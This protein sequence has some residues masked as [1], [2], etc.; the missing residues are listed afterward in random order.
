MF[1]WIGLGRQYEYLLYGTRTVL[2]YASK[3]YEKCDE[4]NLCQPRGP[5]KTSTD[6]AASGRTSPWHF[7]RRT[8]LDT[9]DF[10]AVL[11]YTI[12]DRYWLMKHSGRITESLMSPGGCLN[13]LQARSGR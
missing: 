3:F 6:A 5:N 4:K 10:S 8:H 1:S 11:P 9:S 13:M 7:V 2:D 12:R